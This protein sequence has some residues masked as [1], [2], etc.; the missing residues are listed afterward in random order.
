MKKNP[1]FTGAGTAIIT[2]FNETGID[3]NAF[4]NLIEFQIANSID[5]IIVCGTTGEA[6]TMHDEEHLSAIK[7]VVDT[8]AGRVP[9]IAGTGSNYTAHCIEL[10]QKAEKLGVDGLLV[11]TPYYNKTTQA[12]L[13]KHYEAVANSVNI[14]IIVYNVP[15]RTGL[16][17]SA[18]TLKELSAHKNINAMKEAS[19]DITLATKMAA[20]CG[21]DIIMYSGNDD[22]VVPLM[23]IGGKGVISVVSNIIPKD[24]H[25]MVQKY[26]DGDVVGSRELQLKMMELISA[27]FVEVNPI[28]IKTAMNI[29]GHDAG[30]LRLPLYE[31]SS[32]NLEVLKKALINYGLL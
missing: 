16:N 25:D 10:S 2:P 32:G 1:I 9:V 28:P 21:D 5:A 7:F 24:V 3:F 12:G 8:V 18:A 30:E 20:L 4:G 11:V 23:S 26:L 29:L 13:V 17:M 6:S 22:M 27:A 15:S 31:M 19:G 14:P